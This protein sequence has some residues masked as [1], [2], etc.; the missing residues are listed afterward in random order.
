MRDSPGTPPSAKWFGIARNV[1]EN[2]YNI[3]PTVIR[4]K[5]LSLLMIVLLLL[6]RD[7]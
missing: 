7:K 2:A 6:Y 1:N 3:E 5:S 4:K